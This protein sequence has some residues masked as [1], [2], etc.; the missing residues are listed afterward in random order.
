MLINYIDDD[1][2]DVDEVG[3]NGDDGKG[4]GNDDD[5]VNANDDSEDDDNNDDDEDDDDDQDEVDMFC[6]RRLRYPRYPLG[7]R[8]RRPNCASM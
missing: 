1:R 7:H 5:N 4:N 3:G 2:N 8:L 6:L